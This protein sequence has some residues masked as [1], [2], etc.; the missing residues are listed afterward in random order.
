MKGTVI[1]AQFKFYL[2]VIFIIILT[3]LVQAQPIGYK[4]KI[5]FNEWMDT[6]GFKNPANFIWSDG[7]ITTAVSLID[8]S[9]AL[10]QVSTPQINIWY[11]ITVSNVYDRCGNP[12]NPAK[13]KARCIW[14]TPL[15]VEL[16][17][18]SAEIINENV[19]LKWITKTEVNNY[20][21]EIEKKS[22]TY[23]DWLNIGF[24]EGSGNSNSPKDYQF[25]DKNLIGGSK[26]EY[27][28]KQVDTDGKYEYSDVVKV[29]IIPNSFALYQNF[30]NPFN[31]ATK[32]RYQIPKESKVEIKIYDAVGSEVMT[33]LND[34]KA[35]GVYDEE[36]NA[37]DL[38]SGIYFYRIIAGSF[39]ATKK[40][41]LLK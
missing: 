27:R 26:F 32:I 17:S 35:A 11:T 29:D 41:V 36:L 31:P 5:N 30:P 28:L 34:R 38:A 12:I 2:H 18:F 23:D 10:L 24:V 21:F 9:T 40:M 13:N 4:V 19:K 22:G 15:P 25:I 20:G 8:T 1:L 37:K 14:T 7:L 6:T 3:G 16:S 33:L 39:V